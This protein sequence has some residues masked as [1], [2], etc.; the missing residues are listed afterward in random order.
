MIITTS[1]I[2]LGQTPS[3]V[4]GNNV[5]FDPAN[6]TDPDFSTAYT[7]TDNTG[8]TMD[9]GATGV[10]SYVA[11]AG[12]NIAGNMDFTSWCRVGNDATEVARTF[13]QRN[14]CV[15]IN[16]EPRTFSN[17]R[18]SLF[19]AS[20]DKNP[21]ISF[22]AAGDAITIPNSGEHAGYNRQFLNRNRITKSSLNNLAAPTSYLTKKSSA[23]GTLRLPN[24]TKEFSETEWQT[25][26]DFSDENYFFIREQDPIPVNGETQ[27]DSAY[28][29]FE[30]RGV[31]TM[32]NAQ[33]RSLNDLS[34]SFKVFNGL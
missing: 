17:L 25:F 26:L 5:S 13:I 4:T 18:L 21:S 27:N 30:P 7:S 16:F 1:N 31:K 24:M 19:N 34:I 29:C 32:A 6:I 33:T 22:V 14:N 15:V 8:L 3:I 11:F 28:L 12:I 20:G 2:L 10:I 9:F 23:K